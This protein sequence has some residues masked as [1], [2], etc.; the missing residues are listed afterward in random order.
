MRVL[1]LFVAAVAALVLVAP[2][3]SADPDLYLDAIAP[4]STIPVTNG[5][6]ILGAPDDQ[7]AAISGRQYRFLLL[8]FGAGEEVVGDLEV[9]HRNP[10]NTFW[11]T[12]DVNFVDRNGHDLGWAQL[13]LNG[14]GTQ[15]T[16][17][18]NPSTS[19]Y[20]YVRLRTGLQ[21]VDID[22]MKAAALA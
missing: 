10:P 13:L 12:M 3:A 7:F 20:R 14:S 11:K 6:N 1:S 16:T 22:S 8:D 15:V 21:N 5:P 18:H 2:V 17:V 19:P 4:E 9:R